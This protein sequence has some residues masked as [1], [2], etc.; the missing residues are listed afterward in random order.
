MKIYKN[1][2]LRQEH[3]NSVIAIGNFDGIHIGHQKVIAQAKKKAKEKNLKFGLI[4]F[5]PMPVVFFNSKIKNHRVNSLKQKEFYLKKLKLDFL[6]IIKFNKNFSKISAEKFIHNILFK[7]L[8]SNYIYISKNFKF[9]NKRKGNVKMLKK[10]EKIYLYKTIITSP[11]KK[12]NKIISSSLIR[13]KIVAGKVLDA[14]ILLGR[15]WNIIGKV[16]K[17]DKRGRKIGFPTCN[18]KLN[19]YVIPKLGVYS[20]NV[21]SKSFKKKGIANI[22]YRPTFKGKYLL[23]EVNI[24]GIN[25]NLYKKE[26]KINFIKFIRAEKKFKNVMD[27]KQQIKKDILIAKK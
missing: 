7:K 19:D 6:V 4:T 3:K 13:K 12:T 24:F 26:L 21:Q 2:N 20:V 16:I 25:A 27:L 9:G 10:F 11:L 8:K 17:G 18:I 15:K 14:N 1:L 23:L 22:G 5:E